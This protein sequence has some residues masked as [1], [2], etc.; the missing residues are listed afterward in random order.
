MIRA[1]N[2]T[3]QSYFG[4]TKQLPR[5]G[6]RFVRKSRSATI[7]KDNSFH[8]SPGVFTFGF[9]LAADALLELIT[10][11]NRRDSVV[12]HLHVPALL[13]PTLYLVRHSVELALKEAIA[14]GELEL[15]LARTNFSGHN[16]A[17]L[18]DRFCELVG[19]V[20][21]REK[22]G[23]MVAFRAL[24]QELDGYDPGGAAF[25]YPL[26]TIGR[27]Y[28]FS[29]DGIYPDEF[30]SSLDK[31]RNY[32]KCFMYLVTDL[33]NLEELRSQQNQE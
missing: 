3:F 25:R 24:V 16:L 7:S 29:G 2:K 22:R 8:R 30:R 33:A 19:F 18:S 26:D 14:F 20:A 11:Q 31:T 6:D 28:P 10:L 32:I 13:W 21:P 17:R 1:T 23:S 15:G 9:D 12:D 5:K 27:Q 4:G